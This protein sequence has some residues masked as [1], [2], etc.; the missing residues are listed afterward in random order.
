MEGVRRKKLASGLNGPT[1]GPCKRGHSKKG[2]RP[3]IMISTSTCIVGVQSR[4]DGEEDIWRTEGY[5]PQK[6][7]TIILKRDHSTGMMRRVPLVLFLYR[8]IYYRIESSWRV[9]RIIQT[10]GYELLHFLINNIFRSISVTAK[11]GSKK[12]DVVVHAARCERRAGT[13]R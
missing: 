4:W 8:N 13:G 9:R 7:M 3:E 6:G 12:W 10:P 2:T 11:I 5:T 1:Q